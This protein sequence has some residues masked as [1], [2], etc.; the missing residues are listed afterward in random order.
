MSSRSSSSMQTVDSLLSPDDAA[1]I[2]QG[3]SI[4]VAS[5]D[6][7]HVP[8]LSRALACR[9]VDAQLRLVVSR[10]QCQ[11]LLRDIEKSGQIAVVFTQPSTHRT[12]QIKGRDAQVLPAD[13]DDRQRVAQTEQAFA[14]DLQQIGFGE[15]LVRRMFACDDG[16][17][18]TIGF[19][20]SDLFLQT[21]GPN[22]GTR[23]A[24][25]P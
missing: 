23:L 7:R 21:P 3:V 4:C 10:S 2:Q 11:S 12:L 19:T 22:A 15:A 8:S 16:D 24:G 20:P 14:A 1:F 6:V 18:C 25:T 9:I 5:R 17:L 13:A